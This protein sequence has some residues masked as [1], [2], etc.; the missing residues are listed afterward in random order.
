MVLF[1]HA[2][3]TIAGLDG[4]GVRELARL[5]TGDLV[6]GIVP[7]ADGELA[8][9]GVL[10]HV[11]EVVHLPNGET[12]VTVTGTQ[13]V[14]VVDAKSV[15]GGKGRI[16]A[17][18]DQ[19]A[20]VIP[21]QTKTYRALVKAYQAVLREV[22][23]LSDTLPAETKQRFAGCDVAKSV[24]MIAPYVTMTVAEGIA[25]LAE[26]RIEARVRLMFATLRQER[27]LLQMARQIHEQAASCLDESKRRLYLQEQVRVLRRELG[28]LDPAD[29]KN[30]TLE[31]S[32]QLRKLPLPPPVREAA[33][34]ELSRLDLIPAGT[35]EYIVSHSYLTWIRDLPWGPGERGAPPLLA[36][37]RRDLA[38]DHYGLESVKERIL[39][40]LAVMQHRGAGRGEVLLLHGP[41]GVGKTSL[42]KS[43]AKALGRPLV[44]I[45]LGGVRDE[46][47]I[48]GHRRTYIG[49]IPGK[50]LHAVKQAKSNAPVIL[51]DEID[52]VG[53]D[54]G[55]S[56][57][58][59]A[60][61]EVL[62]TEQSKTF[63][64]H[65]LAVPYDLS[66]AVF[67]ATANTTDTIHPALLDRMEAVAVSSYTE[68]EKLAIATRHL[69]PA[70]RKDLH[71]NK[72]Q[73][74]IQVPVL[75]AVIRLYTQEA[76]VRN[77]KRELERL[78][79]KTV[80][81]LL[82]GTKERITPQS[83]PKLLGQPYYPKD[84]HDQKL[85]PGVA[86]GLAYTGFGGDVLY[87]ESNTMSSADGK[88]GRLSLTGSLGKVMRESAHA[89]L[90]YLTGLVHAKPG[91]LAVTVEQI[92]SANL[93]IH[94]PD[95]ATPKEGPSAGIAIMCALA[96][97]LQ[98]KSLPA[99]LAM[100]GEITLRGQVLAVG[101]IKEKIM[102]AYRAGKTQV[103]IPAANHH[104]V[105][106]IPKEVLRHLDIIEVRTMEEVLFHAG[107][108]VRQ[109]LRKP[110]RS[111]PPLR[112]AAR[113]SL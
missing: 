73:F 108:T 55:R 13:R 48:R 38:R 43:I 83:L 56:S 92:Q 16:N 26:P 75:T 7:A 49:S 5:R 46:A 97:L 23:R 107:L 101:G 57:L 99:S 31:L 71:L 94:F 88:A 32:D 47:E 11:T 93:H 17:I 18:V 66:N 61:L 41:P 60:L 8:R 79:R 42:A 9:Y 14:R 12:G 24:D 34:R 2:S 4:L 96:S 67:I 113:P 59:N 50:L 58:A 10:A 51:L 90:S 100:T 21:K 35:A 109:E 70:I 68:E 62:D 1:P 111:L 86:L 105:Q 36:E 27:E 112:I 52:K 91:L 76:G 85:V 39:E 45:A 110:A 33:D 19:V 95:G 82:E 81:A 102:G 87:I 6:V 98:Q 44:P 63:T 89:A 54:H 40:F 104:N 84:A 25:L 3:L 106:D 53:L 78:G 103:M 15:R 69:L 65:Y 29:E 30:E 64:D 72:N 37:A 28:E 80:K 22:I 74:M 77:L 20:D